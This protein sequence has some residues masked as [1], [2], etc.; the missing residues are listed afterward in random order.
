MY[1]AN[2][3]KS[4]EE[5]SIGI[6]AVDQETEGIP[7]AEEILNGIRDGYALVISGGKGRPIDGVH[8]EIAEELAREEHA[9]NADIS[10]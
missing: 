9:Q 5:A 2:R 6:V 7:T 4:R 3:G 1:P 8:R 10:R